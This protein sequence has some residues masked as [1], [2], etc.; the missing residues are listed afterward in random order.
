M[1]VRTMLLLNPYLGEIILVLSQNTETPVGI[2]PSVL[3]KVVVGQ[4]SGV[5]TLMSHPRMFQR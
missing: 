4:M 3:P 1:D 5:L 2:Q